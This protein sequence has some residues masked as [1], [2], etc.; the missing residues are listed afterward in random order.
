[1]PPYHI[2]QKASMIC[3]LANL[4]NNKTNHMQIGL[5]KSPV[6]LMKARERT[7]Y[8]SSSRAITAPCEAMWLHADSDWWWRRRAK[9]ES[10][11]PHPVPPSFF[12]F[13][14]AARRSS[15]DLHPKHE[16]QV[17]AANDYKPKKS[18]FWGPFNPGSFSGVCTWSWL[19]LIW[20]WQ[21][22]HRD[23]DQFQ[24]FIFHCVLVGTS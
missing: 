2:G 18:H 7:W 4:G 21:S 20:N 3:C 14:E 16:A 9:S 22:V 19:W 6:V 17:F 1:M 12:F 10:P 23:S 24:S 5:L 15:W 8:D 11:R 13:L